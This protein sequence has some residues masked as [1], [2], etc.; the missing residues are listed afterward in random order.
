M[1]T[2]QKTYK[3]CVAALSPSQPKASWLRPALKV[4][5]NS[6]CDPVQLQLAQGKVC[7]YASVLPK[8]VYICHFNFYFVSQLH[9]YHFKAVEKVKFLMASQPKCSLSVQL[10]KCM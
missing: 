4:A 2:T 10:Q 6:C 1:T 7:D 3:H 5:T 8:Y 9:K